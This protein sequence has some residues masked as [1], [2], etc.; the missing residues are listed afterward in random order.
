VGGKEEYFWLTY[1]EVQLASQELE[2]DPADRILHSNTGQEG[3]TLASS[4]KNYTHTLTHFAL[5]S[6]LFRRCPLPALL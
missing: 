4:M 5:R 3:L 2:V 6:R 1:F